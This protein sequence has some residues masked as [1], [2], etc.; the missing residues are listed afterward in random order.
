MLLLRIK[1]GELMG[2]MRCC[3]SEIRWT[4]HLILLAIS[5]T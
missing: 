2:E 3:W 1:R 5:L 4:V